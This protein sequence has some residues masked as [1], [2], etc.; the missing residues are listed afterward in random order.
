MSNYNTI[1]IKTLCIESKCSEEVIKEILNKYNIN[2]NRIYDINEFILDKELK[3]HI[4]QLLFLIVKHKEKPIIYLGETHLEK[5][6]KKTTKHFNYLEFRFLGKF[7]GKKQ[8]FIDIR[9]LKFENILEKAEEIKNKIKNYTNYIIKQKNGKLD[10]IYVGIAPRKEERG[11]A[12]SSTAWTYITFDIDIEEWKTNKM[13][14]EE[15]ILK[16][17]IEYLSK[18]VENGIL[19]HKVAFTGGGLRFIIYPERPILEEELLILKQIAEKINAD[20]AM[21]DLPRVDRLIGTYNYKEKYGQPRPCV[22]IAWLKDEEDINKLLSPI[23]LYKKFGIINDYNE[24]KELFD[25]KKED[26]E[27]EKGLNNLNKT[28]RRLLKKPNLNK[29]ILNDIDRKTYKWLSSIQYKLTEKLGKRW[30]EKLLSHLGIDYKYG[31]NGDR[32]DFWSLFFDDGRNPDCSIYINQGY[33]AVM[34][35]FHHPD[36]RFIALAGLWMVKEFRDKIIE[37]LKLY[38]INPNQSIYKTVKDVMNDLLNRETIK[39]EAEGY[40]P[41]EAIIEAFKLSIENKTPVF[42]KADTGRGKTYTITRNAADIIN[43]FN[44][45]SI[46]VLFPYKIQVLQVGNSLYKE[47]VNVPMYHEDG[48]KLGKDT[49]LHLILGTYDQVENIFND[50]C[51]ITI[52]GEKEKIREEEFILLTI[53]EAHD[54]II[55][56][57]FRK[58]AIGGVRRCIEKSGGCVLLTATP[59]L[60]NLNN[61]PVIEVDFKDKRKLFER[62]SIHVEQN[63][64]IGEFCEYIL[65][66]FKQGFVK[67]ALVLVDSKKLIEKI[68]YSLELYGFDKPIYVITR[69]TVGIDEASKMIINEEKVPEEGLILATR[70]ISEGVNIK[71]KVDLVWA[72]YCRSATTIRQFI[73]RCRNGGR[74]LIITAS[75]KDYSNTLIMDYNRIIEEYKENYKLLK[76]FLETDIETLKELDKEYKNV[77]ISEIQKAI[78]YDEERRDW[79]LD[80]DTLAHTYNSLLEAYITM[81][82]RLLKEYLEKTTGYEFAVKTIKELE[83]TELDKLLKDEHI[84]SIERENARQIITALKHYGVNK[85]KSAIEYNNYDTFN[86]AL[87]PQLIKRYTKRVNRSI[88][89]LKDI[90]NIPELIEPYVS[91]INYKEKKLPITEDKLKKCIEEIEEFKKLAKELNENEDRVTKK[92]NS[93]DLKLLE[94]HKDKFSNLSE[95][96]EKLTY[97]VFLCSPSKWGKIQ[98]IIRA[99]WNIVIGEEDERLKNKKLGLKSLIAKVLVKTKEFALE[100]TKFKIGELINLI[101]EECGF[102][103]KLEEAKQL[104]HAIFNCVIRGVKKLKENAIVK[105]KNIDK[106]FEKLYNILKVNLYSNSVDKCEKAIENEIAKNDGKIYELDLYE[107]IVNKLKFAEEVFYKALEK[108]KQL[109]VI[110]EPK[111]GLL[112]MT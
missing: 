10:G 34:V 82:Y 40:L 11:D 112:H 103:L 97:E 60:V 68:K 58:R 108:L 77:I 24:F 84:K 37:F 71:N 62:C 90:Y 54:L 105:I 53:D 102:N 4:A 92:I 29:T 20:T 43:T 94:E 22:T 65:T 52:D 36:M 67:N 13:P 45:S 89:V 2:I 74:E 111:S 64:R 3:Q 14:T 87:T 83:E 21:Y 88:S 41:K 25:K 106:D 5:L 6:L 96:V 85:I 19:P 72:L 7:K 1:T 81:D 12:K 93:I 17:L 50:L 33:N 15:E 56:K 32:L 35:D 57:E 38:D 63:D 30:I 78:Y 26:L 86:D 46:T 79:V 55:Q 66:V 91:M 8:I 9:D 44:K 42:L 99:V 76:E 23:I 109:G 18:F 48:K 31:R 59:E 70:V 39:I 69:E 49:I 98:R 61:Y 100:K 16:K 95:V 107:I 110:F 101:K 75:N 104:L 73:A 47:G 51:Y 28:I 80:E 27:N